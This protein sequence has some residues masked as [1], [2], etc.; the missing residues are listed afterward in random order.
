M[1]GKQQKLTTIFVSSLLMFANSKF[2]I[3]SEHLNLV[4]Q[5]D[6]E[7]EANLIETFT[8]ETD[9]EGVKD[10]V[11]V[12]E[13]FILDENNEIKDTAEVVDRIVDTKQQHV[14]N[15]NETW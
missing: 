4:K 10:K 15:R 1:K 2:V 6:I 7:R 11:R 14:I 5:T 9:C 8:R 3:K 13:I 12:Y